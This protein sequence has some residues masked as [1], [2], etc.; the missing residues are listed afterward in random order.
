MRSKAEPENLFQKQVCRKQKNHHM[1]ALGKQHTAVNA[2][3]KQCMHGVDK[4]VH[5]LRVH[6]VRENLPLR[7]GINPLVV[8][9]N[10]A[11]TIGIIL[12]SA[13]AEVHAAEHQQ[14]KKKSV[15]HK[16]PLYPLKAFF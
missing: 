6:A 3:T 4:A 7:Q 14:H 1:N 5:P 12:K 15:F 13:V 8:G 10:I 2:D 9:I 11:E 16:M